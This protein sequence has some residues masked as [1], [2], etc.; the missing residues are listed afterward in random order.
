M[1]LDTNNHSV[2]ML[3]GLLR[4]AEVGGVGSAETSVGRSG[5]ALEPGYMYIYK[6]SSGIPPT[7]IK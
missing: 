4:F 7:S 2:N 5:Q 6:G 3:W 1:A